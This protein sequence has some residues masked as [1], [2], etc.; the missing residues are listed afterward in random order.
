MSS[1]FDMNTESEVKYLIEKATFNPCNIEEYDLRGAKDFNS[2]KWVAST[3]IHHLHEF[4][5]IIC[6]GE[7]K[8]RIKKQ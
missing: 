3:N 4:M 1:L 5:K 2:G 6:E 7:I 8:F